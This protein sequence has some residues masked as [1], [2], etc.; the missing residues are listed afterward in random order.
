LNVKTAHIDYEFLLCTL[1]PE[2]QCQEFHRNH[3]I[4]RTKITKFWRNGND[5]KQLYWEKGPSWSWS[6]GSWI[7]NYLC[8]QCLSPLMLRVRIQL[9]WGVLDTTLCDKVCQWLATGQW[10]L[11]EL[12]FPTPIKLT[13]T[14]FLK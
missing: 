11:W 4:W 7:Y 13:V 9:G 1:T 14:I 8:N 10:F 2:V 6:Y 5:S 3:V 12:L